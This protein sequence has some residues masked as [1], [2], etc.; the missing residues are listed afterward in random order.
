MSD[1]VPLCGYYVLFIHFSV[2][3]MDC[4]HFLAIVSDAPRSPTPGLAPVRVSGENVRPLIPVAPSSLLRKEVALT[5]GRMYAT[6]DNESHS[7]KS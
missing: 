4:F 7:F 1:N 3:H 5:V 2:V 6:S